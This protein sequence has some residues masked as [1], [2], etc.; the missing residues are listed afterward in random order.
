MSDTFVFDMPVELSLEF[1]AA[2]GSD[3]VDAEWELFTHIIH[4]V[5][6][7]SLIV[8]SIY[9]QCPHPRSIIDGGVLIPFNRLVVFIQEFQELN[10]HLYMMAGH[11]FLVALGM[12]FPDSGAPG[13]SV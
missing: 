2:I 12:H 8:T 9:L 11:L 13:Q 1:V 6:G 4:E 7:V 10:I 5:T 3:C